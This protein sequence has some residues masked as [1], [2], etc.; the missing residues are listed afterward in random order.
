MRQNKEAHHY[1]GLYKQRI[2]GWHNGKAPYYM[3]IGKAVAEEATFPVLNI[4]LTPETTTP[5]RLKY[6]EQRLSLQ[7]LSALQ[8]WI[9]TTENRTAEMTL[10]DIIARSLVK[11]KL[12]LG[13]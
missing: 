10:G 11:Q 5:E 12:N 8:R 1:Y 4:V 6:F 2:I 3:T 9:A 13:N 7:H